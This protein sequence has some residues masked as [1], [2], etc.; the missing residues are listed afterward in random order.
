MAADD[1]TLFPTAPKP[2][3]P[4]PSERMIHLGSKLGLSPSTIQAFVR[5]Y[6]LGSTGSAL[7]L[8]YAFPPEGGIENAYTYVK[9]ILDGDDEA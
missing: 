4:K 7:G 9:S 8:A 6:G 2:T 5:D 1:P 3:I